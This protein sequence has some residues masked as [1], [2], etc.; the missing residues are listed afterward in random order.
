M[1]KRKKK[2]SKRVV[3][4]TIELTIGRYKPLDNKQIEDI[5]LFLRT[6]F[7]SLGNGT[8]T[9]QALWFISAQLEVAH[10]CVEK[11]VSVENKTEFLD[12]CKIAMQG[13]KRAV[14]RFNEGKG[15]GLDGETFSLCRDIL[16]AHIDHIRGLGQGVINDAIN[17]CRARA[18]RGFL[19][20]AK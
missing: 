7:L 6:H 13:I 19:E 10:L 16:N 1:K 14:K 8:G 18:G 5:D 20:V 2:Y 12:A 11:D 15:I 17:E 9:E 3:K 4:N